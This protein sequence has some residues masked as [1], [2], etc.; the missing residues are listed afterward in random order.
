MNRL[1]ESLE[2]RRLM[3]TT[4]TLNVTLA[5]GVLTIENAQDLQAN[6]SF[7][8]SVTH[9]VVTTQQPS[10]FVG[11][12]VTI[13]GT[14]D[15]VTRIVI[16]GTIGDDNITLGMNT[17]G[18][19]ASINTGNG[20]DLVSISGSGSTTAVTDPDSAIVTIDAGNS[21]DSILVFGTTYY[22]YP[23]HGTD[24]VENPF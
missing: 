8:G 5:G 2:G 7:D 14:F 13:H 6:A 18:I 9:V 1:I 15:G 24:T 16:T 12:N 3:S 20:R 22:I 4:P 11:D 19:T 21:K 10:V 23:T 17:A